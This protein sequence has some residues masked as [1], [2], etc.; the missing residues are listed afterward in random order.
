MSD[1]TRFLLNETDLPRF[2]YNINA[3]I[4]VPSAPI[5]NPQTK[6]PVTPEFLSVRFPCARTCSTANA[7]GWLP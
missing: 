1:Q 5:L 4:P 7:P 2:W 3:D 6:E